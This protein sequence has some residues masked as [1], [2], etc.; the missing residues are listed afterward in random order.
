MR[1]F[2]MKQQQQHHHHARMDPNDDGIGP[3]W[4][5]V[6]DKPFALFTTTTQGRNEHVPPSVQLDNIPLPSDT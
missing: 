1:Q 5:T 4:P 6:P 2:F 3:E